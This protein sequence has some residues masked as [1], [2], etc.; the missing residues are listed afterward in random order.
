M[1]DVIWEARSLL[2]D[3]TPLHTDC[4]QVCD[5]RCCKASQGREGMLLF[6]GEE[7]LYRNTDFQLKTTQGGTLLTCDGRCDRSARPLACRIFPL[8]PHVDA[9][10]RVSAV[11]DP[12]G[13]SLCPLVFEAA[14]VP[15]ERAFVRA[16]RRAGRILMQDAACA[17]F[18]REQSEEI[19]ELLRLTPLCEVRSPIKRRKISEK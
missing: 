17:V 7:R 11:Y 9:N 16:V 14:H 8:F 3:I 12:R 10:G 19:D 6:P 18:L 1:R 13:Y 15:L 5:G 4:G 2:E